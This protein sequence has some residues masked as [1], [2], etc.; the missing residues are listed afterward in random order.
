M[1][2][3]DYLSGIG[4]DIS[5]YNNKNERR[6]DAIEF[7]QNTYNDLYDQAMENVEGVEIDKTKDRPMDKNATLFGLRMVINNR[8]KDG[9]W[10][11]V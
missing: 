11:L 1:D 6:P 3:I 10:K 7:N 2:K 9:N 5:K 4:G 8:M